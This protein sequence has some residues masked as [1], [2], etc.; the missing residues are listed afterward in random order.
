MQKTFHIGEYCKYGTIKV[1]RD[2]LHCKV[3]VMDYKTKNVRVRES[4]HF[5]DKAKMQWFLED[6]TT[7][8]YADKIINHFY[9]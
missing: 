4:F 1:T 9:A 6:Y 8:F 7:P 3:E 2:D 5:V